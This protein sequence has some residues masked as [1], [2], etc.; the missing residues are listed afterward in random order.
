M[1]CAGQGLS[2]EGGQMPGLIYKDRGLIN[3]EYRIIKSADDAVLALRENIAQGGDVIKIYANNTPDNTMLSVDEIR[4]IVQEAH[5]YGS[6][7]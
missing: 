3:E 2:T 4:A 1:H 6:Q 7:I 5:R